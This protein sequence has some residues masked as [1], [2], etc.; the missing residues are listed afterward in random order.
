MPIYKSFPRFRFTKKVIKK[1]EKNI[2][3]VLNE[4]DFI[5]NFIVGHWENPQLELINLLKKRYSNTTTSLI[6]HH[7]SDFLIE[8]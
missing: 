8:L 6:F 1:Q 5:P 4:V 3:K 2:Y 7:K